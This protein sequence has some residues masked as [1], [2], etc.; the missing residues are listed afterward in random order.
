MAAASTTSLPAR[1]QNSLANSVSSLL[2]VLIIGSSY[3]KRLDSFL[4]QDGI[5]NFGL[6]E[7][8][9]KI[10]CFGYGGLLAHEDPHSRLDRLLGRLQRE[11]FVVDIILF[12]VGSNDLSNNVGPARVGEAV[13]EW[14]VRFRDTLNPSKCV[15][16]SQ[17]LQR[18]LQPIPSFNLLVRD[19]NEW[20]SSTLSNH[21]YA[22]VS[23]WRHRAGLWQ[24][25]CGIYAPDGVHLSVSGLRL[26]HRS[27]K[28]A[29]YRHRNWF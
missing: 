7:D 18:S 25:V 2:S 10:T 26:F 27:L 9:Y 5:L 12:H 29:I 3:V 4:S 14:A 8:I 1:A 21:S 22:K 16:V 20:L 13:V 24:P 23:F 19:T 11:A 17:L 15:V 28:D 6:D